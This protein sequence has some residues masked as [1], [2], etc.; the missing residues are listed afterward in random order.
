MIIEGTFHVLIIYILFGLILC[1]PPLFF[2]QWKS[3]IHFLNKKEIH[4]KGFFKKLILITGLS[5]AIIAIILMCLHHP[6]FFN[7]E[8]FHTI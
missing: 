5:I 1:L 7:L 3:F 2:P 6:Y 4:K 8:L